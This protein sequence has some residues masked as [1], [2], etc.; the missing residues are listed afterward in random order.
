[1]Q[2]DEPARRSPNSVELD[3]LVETADKLVAATT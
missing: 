2:R 1:M 3:K